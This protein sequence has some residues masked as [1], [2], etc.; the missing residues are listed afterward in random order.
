MLLKKVFLNFLQLYYQN[1]LDSF[2]QRNTKND[3]YLSVNENLRGYG[4]VCLPK[5]VK[6]LAALTKKLNIS[7]KLFQAID[8][9]N[10][11]LETTVFEGMRKK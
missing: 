2:L 6:A 3:D 7:L 9:D 4:G 1:V 8:Q 11:M 10:K 5:D